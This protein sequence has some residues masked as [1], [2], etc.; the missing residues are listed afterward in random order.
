MAKKPES[1][2][3]MPAEKDAPAKAADS[4][5]AGGDQA[6][7]QTGGTINLVA[8]YVKDLS[9]ENP[10]APASLQN[11]TGQP[12]INVTI[13]VNANPLSETD[14]E[15]E[16]KLDAKA[17]LDKDILFAC[18]LSYAG[19]F[20]VQ[21]FP[22]EQVHPIVLIECPRILFPFARQIIAE[23]TRNGGFP[24]LLIDPIDFVQLYRQRAAA[25]QVQTN[26]Q[27]KPLS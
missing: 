6:Q 9:F 10:R 26:L 2:T 3:D 17:M 15:V 19:I 12:A 20:K 23:A 5:A 24:P 22:K 21:G 11:R 4:K 14:F 16:L 25:A 18:D 8:Q 13:N 1:A 27:D 7:P